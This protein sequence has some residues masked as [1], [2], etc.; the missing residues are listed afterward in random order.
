MKICVY[1]ISKNEINFI[2]RFYQSAKAADLVVLADTGSTDG[3]R[4][5]ARELGITTH[6]I[7][8]HPWRFDVARNVALGL[9][10]SDVDVC[11]SLDVD[12]VLMPGWREEIE[13]VWTKE[14][15]RLQY[16]YDWSKGHIFNATKIHHRKGYVWQSICHEM[17]FPDPRHTEVWATTDFLLIRHLPDDTKSR[18][19]YLPQLQ[20]NALEQPYNARN[21]YYYARELYF[22]QQYD[23]SIA[24]FSRYLDLPDAKWYHERSYALRTIAKCYLAKGMVLEAKQAAKKA[25][26]EAENLRENWCLLA[27]ICQKEGNWGG[28]YQAAS[29]A[30]KIQKRE[31]AYTSD[32]RVWGSLPYDLAALASY[33]MGFKERARLYGQQALDLDPNNSRLI[34]N[35]EW[36]SK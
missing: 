6:D 3:T 20:A 22:N 35:M 11:I 5:R 29:R 1:A 36:Y 28:S 34:S 16:R 17:I 25:T 15:T 12:E 21:S 13:R 19:D 2:D 33:Y 30:L 8:I 4:E 18:S 31:Y 26:K 14:T 23:A 32:E 27:E 24:E 10:P 7:Y 9:I